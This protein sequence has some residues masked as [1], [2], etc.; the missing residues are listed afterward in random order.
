MPFFFTFSSDN[1]LSKQDV[2]PG[3]SVLVA[4]NGEVTWG[5]FNPFVRRVKILFLFLSQLKS[6]IRKMK[7]EGATSP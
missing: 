3:A 7:G 4:S 6:T 1:H 5:V 2:V